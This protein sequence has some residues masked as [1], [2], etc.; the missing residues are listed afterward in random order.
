MRKP[1]TWLLIACLFC[2]AGCGYH[3][4]KVAIEL[5]SNKQSYRIGE[6]IIISCVIK[7]ITWRPISIPNV[8]YLTIGDGR[9]CQYQIHTGKNESTQSTMLMPFGQIKKIVLKGLAGSGY[10]VGGNPQVC[11]QRESGAQPFVKEGQY[12]INLSI[13]TPKKKTMHTT[14]MNKDWSNSSV[15]ITVNK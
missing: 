7:N 12:K 6:P 15:L 11:F 14:R 9:G 2:I 10:N 8:M 5:K 1:K 13:F 4:N 3:G